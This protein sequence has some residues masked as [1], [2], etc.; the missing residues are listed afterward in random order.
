VVLVDHWI[1]IEDYHIYLTCVLCTSVGEIG[2]LHGLVLCTYS[3]FCLWIYI[4]VL[5]GS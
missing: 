4:Q 3:D 2:I 1:I 5:N